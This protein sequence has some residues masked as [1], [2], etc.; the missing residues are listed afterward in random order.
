MFAFLRGT[1]AFKGL[2]HIALDVQGVGYAVVVPETVFR[3]LVPNQEATLLTYC[4]IREDLFQIYG[5]LKEEERSLF[6][7]L[8]SIN[9]V[10]PKVAMAILSAMPVAEFGR[11]VLEHDVKAFT[12]VT[13][14][15]KAMAQRL[16]LEMNSKM[17]KNPELDAI[18][19][20][21]ETEDTPPE[22]DDVYEALMSLG[23]HTVE[24]KRAAAHARKKLKDD[25]T[26][27]ALVREALRS[28]A[29]VK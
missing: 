27:E 8:I 25:A 7:T 19:G 4:H 16:V 12:R 13:G 3:K 11:A 9:K 23:C 26:D 14:V 18:L 6:L 29:K 5:F 15:G 21:A 22:G 20:R 17:G 2:D 24:A 1:V 10:G 28:M